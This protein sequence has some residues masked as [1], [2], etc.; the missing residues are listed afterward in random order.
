M[1]YFKIECLIFLGLQIFG[2]DPSCAYYLKNLI[3]ALFKRTIC[4][5]TNIK[6]SVLQAM[7][8]FYCLDFCYCLMTSNHPLYLSY[9][10]VHCQT[11]H[12]RWLF[13]IGI[14]MHSLLPSTFYSICCISNVSWLLYDWYYRT[15][16]VLFIIISLTSTLISFFEFQW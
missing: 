14:K 11:R 10:G 3:E 7:H 1:V 15:A 16:Q 4:L 8:V 2:S 12:S 6:V 13:F 9:S 5:L